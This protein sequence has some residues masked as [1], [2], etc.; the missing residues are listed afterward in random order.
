MATG[1]W[2]LFGIN[3]PELGIT[4]KFGGNKKSITYS[5]PA[6]ASY[7]SYQSVPSNSGGSTL[8][9]QQTPSYKAPKPS[10]GSS[11]GSS[12]G[13]GYSVTDIFS[14]LGL[15]K[16][17][18][19]DYYRQYGVDN[20]MDFK[21]AYLANQGNPENLYPVIDEN[22]KTIA[23][24]IGD[25]KA[26]VPNRESAD[27]G[28]LSDQRDLMRGSLTRNRDYASE[29]LASQKQTGI[30]ELADQFRSG[31]DAANM[32]I[33]SVG[34]GNS[35]ATGMASYALQK[36]ANKGA[37]ALQRE[38]MAKQADIDNTYQTESAGID[39]W[40]GTNV[41]NV[42]NFYGDLVNRLDEQ[43]MNADEVKGNL[44]LNVKQAIIDKANTA[45]SNLDNEQATL[46][47]NLQNWAM[48]RM[49]ELNNA[50]ITMANST[51]DPYATLAS[52]MDLGTSIGLG[53]GGETAYNPYLLKKKQ[54]DYL[55]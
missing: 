47:S 43:M 12:G 23:K 31:A 10:G 42:K 8:G 6:P 51:F 45:L 5:S 40:F 44:L 37:T 20:A 48:Q 14:E 52:E 34:G 35:S 2:N 21:K 9:A 1:N 29:R 33:G 49:A 22:Y 4:E 18:K 55:A 24:R 17:K 39:E 3:L 53:G 19:R 30:R 16:G 54:T 25:L 28:Y 7:S 26:G 15:D 27:V 13:V 50:K 11:G 32:M 38:Q 36:Q 41:Q 46:R